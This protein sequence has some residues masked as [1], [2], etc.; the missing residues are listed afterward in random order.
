MALIRHNRHLLKRLY[1]H[2]L[3][4]VQ[5][6]CPIV[7]LCTTKGKRELSAAQSQSECYCPPLTPQW[8]KKERVGI[9]L[10]KSFDAVAAILAVMKVSAVY[11]PLDV[12]YPEA[13]LRFMIT[14]LSSTPLSPISRVRQ[15]CHS[16]LSGFVDVIATDS[17]LVSVSDDVAC[18]MQ[19]AAYVIYTSGSTGR[20]KGVEV[21]HGGLANTIH[22]GQKTLGISVGD[23]VLHCMSLSFDAGTENLFNALCFG[24][25]IY[26]VEA[27][28]TSEFTT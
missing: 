7:L 2:Y 21:L 25:S 18:E 20:P 9:C 14:T 28:Q 13:R 23:R 8:C 19:D 17:A 10:L 6:S 4:N 1:L 5:P 3:S 16:L 24:A 27:E 11:V 12:K 26:L 15:Q 22:A